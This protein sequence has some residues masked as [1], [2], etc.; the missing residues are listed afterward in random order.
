MEANILH[1]TANLYLYQAKRLEL[2]LN[3]HTRAIT[4]GYPPTREAGI[5]TMQRLEM[6]PAALRTAYNHH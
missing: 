2:R 6:Y 4:I 3:G 1:E 5:R